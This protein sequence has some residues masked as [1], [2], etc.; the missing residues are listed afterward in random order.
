[1]QTRR[2]FLKT[3]AMSV[4]SVALMESPTTFADLAGRKDLPLHYWNALVLERNGH[5]LRLNINN[6][7]DY[8]AACY[9]LRDTHVNQSALAH[10]WLLHTLSFLQA[11]VAQYHSHEPWIINSGFRT[12][13]TNKQVG[14]AEHS[15]HL[16]NTRGFFHAADVR[17]KHVSAS[18]INKYALAT[19][20]GGVGVYLKSDFVHIDVGPPRSWSDI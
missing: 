14:G 10:P 3:F 2:A 12:P 7:Q 15:Y 13:H 8:M 5:L 11:L 6:R 19:R 9:L 16:A 1:M 20:Q 4:A 18:I 17:T